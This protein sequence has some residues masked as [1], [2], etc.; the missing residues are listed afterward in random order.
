MSFNMV[1][2]ARPI[3][4]QDNWGEAAKARW[5]K[6]EAWLVLSS[7]Y[8]PRWNPVTKVWQQVELY[9][10]KHIASGYVAAHVDSRRFVTFDN[11]ED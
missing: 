9:K 10:A 7:F 2:V 1:M 5:K 6:G 4:N 8:G 3:V 11:T